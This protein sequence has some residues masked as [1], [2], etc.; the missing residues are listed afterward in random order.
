MYIYS[1]DNNVILYFIFTLL[2]LT[3]EIN[4]THFYDN[5]IHTYIYNYGI[6]ITDIKNI[7]RQDSLFRTQ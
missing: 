4:V 2:Y 5:F 1:R 7:V 6:F 3:I